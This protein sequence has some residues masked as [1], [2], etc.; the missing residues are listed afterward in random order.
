M[1]LPQPLLRVARRR[2]FRRPLNMDTALQTAF[3]SLADDIKA[4]ALPADRQQTAL[5]C[6]G[7]LPTLYTKFRMT[8][9]SRYGDEITRMVQSV[10]KE[11]LL[12]S[13]KTNPAALEL[14]ATLPD[15]FQVLHE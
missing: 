14:A 6:L 2:I 9:E 10:L 4:A 7:Q 8:S 11:L 3:G 13:K 15:R 1:R 12:Q 5:W